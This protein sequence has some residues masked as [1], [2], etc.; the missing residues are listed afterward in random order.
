MY[1]VVCASIYFICKASSHVLFFLI[2][3]RPTW[4]EVCLL[5][6]KIVEKV[7]VGMLRAESAIC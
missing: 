4:R 2:A 5:Y 6:V 1:E 3:D 7:S